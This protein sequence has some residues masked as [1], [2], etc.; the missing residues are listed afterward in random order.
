[1]SQK[2][3]SIQTVLL[4]A[5][6]ALFLLTGCSEKQT[7]VLKLGTN[8]WP[9]YEPLYLAREYGYLDED[10]V[11]LV[12][13]SS[14]SQV[15]Q[16]FRNDL[17]D[18]AALTLDEVLMLHETEEDL[19]IVLVMDV[20]HGGDT[21]IGQKGMTSM[22]DLEGKRIGV[23][24]TALGAY[25]VS[26]ALE[27]SGLNPQSLNIINLDV[28]EHEAAFMRKEIDA[29][30]T[31][32]PVQSKLL[33]AG[34]K[35]LFDSSQISGEIVDVLVVRESYLR[36]SKHTIKHLVDGWYRA[37]ADISQQPRKTAEILGQ[38]MQLDV[39]KTLQS[40]EGLRLPSREK[41]QELLYG[42]PT[43]KLLQTGRKLVA[44]MREK[45]LL[46]KEVELTHLL[47]QSPF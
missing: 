11:H 15:I 23:E 30:V 10:Q 6:L 12:E 20:S 35:K 46:H 36:E 13:Y 3:L 14:S 47:T 26:R 8:V 32:E 39:D 31:F 38:R 37:L 27:V 9:G 2:P 24:G 5:C 44:V 33:G 43:P 21:I 22:A 25:M 17:V 29:V 19:K 18:A 34:G 16:A 4:A 1:M 28:H 41:N 7:P 40:Y 42:K 45:G